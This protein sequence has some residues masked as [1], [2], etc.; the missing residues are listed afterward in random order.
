MRSQIL[1]WAAV[2]VTSAAAPLVAAENERVEVGGGLISQNSVA[3]GAL[4]ATLTHNPDGSRYVFFRTTTSVAGASGFTGHVAV[5]VVSTVYL[6]GSFAHTRPSLDTRITDDVENP[7]VVTAS[8][9]FSQTAFDGSLRYDLPW[10]RF[11]GASWF[12]LGGAGRLRRSVDGAASPFQEG[13]IVHAG[14]GIRYKL[15]S[16][17]GSSILKGVG[18]R[19]DARAQWLGSAFDYQGA[20]RTT[21]AFRAEALLMF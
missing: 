5:R 6:E 9:A 16:T 10:L 3:A 20:R 8:T 19:V 13:T 15:W 21:P 4:P 14:G 17:A 7:K 11:G 2:L 1:T 18:L 12:V